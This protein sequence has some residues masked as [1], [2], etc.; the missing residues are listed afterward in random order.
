MTL[1]TDI[2]LYTEK[3]SYASSRADNLRIHL[4]THD[5]KKSVK[6]RKVLIPLH[7]AT[8]YILKDL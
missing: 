3:L 8:S 6:T 5:G 2:F 7:T 4:K 1:G